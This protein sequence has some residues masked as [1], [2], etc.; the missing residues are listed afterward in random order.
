MLLLVLAGCA[1]AQN[2]PTRE[3]GA[4]DHSS[5]SDATEDCDARVACARTTPR[6]EPTV[7]PKQVL[8]GII[9]DR[10]EGSHLF[11]KKSGRW[12]LVEENPSAD[13]R[14]NKGPLRSGCEK[15]YFDITSKIRI[16]RKDG[17]R[18]TLAN[19]TDLKNGQTVSADYTGYEVAESYPGQT[20]AR[21]VVIL[22]TT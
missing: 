11:P 10:G 22:G 21:E 9:T 19:A 20:Y 1:Q 3:A 8:T 7:Y 6:R 5:G 4:S 2:P 18:R 15:I 14:G 12:I 13:C 17:S 16:F